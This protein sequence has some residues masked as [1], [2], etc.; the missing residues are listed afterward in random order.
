[1]VMPFG[2]E[3][4]WRPSWGL[5]ERTYVR[6]LGVLDLPNRLRARLVLNELNALKYRKVLD[7]GSGTGCYSFYLSRDDRIE[8]SAVEIDEARVSDSSHIAKHLKKRNLNFYGGSA[9]GHLQ[10]FPSKTFEIAL[11]IEVFQYIPDVPFTLRE[12]YRVLKPGG[13]LFGHVPVLGYL[14]PQEKTLFDDRIIQMM[15]SEQ[16]FQIVKIIPTFGGMLYEFC[17]LF[18]RI[19]RSRFLAGI[20]FPLIL[21]TSTAFSVEN[22]KGRYRFFMARKPAE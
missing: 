5:I 8:V 9:N 10:K 7:V 16:N 17:G 21:L 15:L 12:I 22:P 1:M 14:R 6:L 2:I 3:Y 18:D 11:A 13:H 4:A 20:L 19:S